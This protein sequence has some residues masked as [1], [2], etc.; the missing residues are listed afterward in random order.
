MYIVVFQNSGRTY[1]HIQI[2][3]IKRKFLFPHNNAPCRKHMPQND[4]RKKT[5]HIQLEGVTCGTKKEMHTP[6]IRTV[7]IWTFYLIFCG[8]V[9]V[10]KHLELRNCGTAGNVYCMLNIHWKANH[11]IIIE[12]TR[13]VLNG[14]IKNT[15]TY[16]NQHGKQPPD[17]FNSTKR[18]MWFRIG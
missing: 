5:S 1:S 17:P 6:K 9:S 13:W 11:F 4:Q 14:H 12:S 3:Q 16:I 2:S 18:R 8:N 15:H 10:C 7:L